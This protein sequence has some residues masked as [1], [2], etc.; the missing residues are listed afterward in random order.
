MAVKLLRQQAVTCWEAKLGGTKGCDH[1]ILLDAQVL[2]HIHQLDSSLAIY[3]GGCAKVQQLGFCSTYSL[4]DL[5]SD[6]TKLLQNP[7]MVPKVRVKVHN[8]VG[9]LDASRSPWCFNNMRG[10]IF[11]KLYSNLIQSHVQSS[12]LANTQLLR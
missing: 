9:V 7:G 8:P 2:G 5:H 3:P 11:Q 12:F 6:T 1:N 4:N 10:W